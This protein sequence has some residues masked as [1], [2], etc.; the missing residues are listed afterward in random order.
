L[1][2]DDH[3]MRSRLRSRPGFALAIALA[4]IVIIGAIITGMFFASTQEYRISRNSAMQ[5]RALTAAEYGL[6]RVTTYG[7][8]NPVWNTDTNG[9][10]ATQSFL[11][12]DGAFDTVRVTKLNSGM[13]MLTSTGRVGPASGAQARH[14]VGGLV[15]L[16]IPQINMLGALTTRGSAKIGGS[17]YLDGNDTT[18][19][20]W[21]CPP[22]GAGV[23]GLSM[24]DTTKITTSG[25]TGLSCVA[26]APK[27]SQDSM[28]GKDSTY[29]NFGPQLSWTDLVGMANKTFP[30]STT[31]NGLGPT[32]AGGSCDTGNQNNWGDPLH[33]DPTV[34]SCQSYFP[35]IYA[36]G[37]LHLSGG[38]GQGI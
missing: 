36:Q 37:N 22:P 38:V 27:V 32:I 11:P 14:R 17:S 24:P 12:G 34:S 23:A 2:T 4:A 6:N 10:I 31:L 26:G 33:T 16:L 25:C 5:A 35:I 29:F 21:N 19:A 28:A 18:Y 9:L 20:G 13:F 15:T 3:S 8:W 1:H 7:Q 30:A